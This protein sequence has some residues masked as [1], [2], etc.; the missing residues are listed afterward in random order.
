MGTISQWFTQAYQLIFG[1]R[2]NKNERYVS[3]HQARTYVGQQGLLT[4]HK[5]HDIGREGEKIARDFL[6]ARG[7]LLREHN[8]DSRWGELDLIMDDNGTV[9]FVEVRYRSNF[10][11]GTPLETINHAKVK[12]MIKTAHAYIK[13]KKLYGKPY[14]FD[15]I[16][17]SALKTENHIEWIKNAIEDTQNLC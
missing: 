12:K 13:Q 14:R 2:S 10:T 7:L 5:I 1:F 4:G 11:H 3:A 17:I 16:A 8:Y 9:T 15:V 6:K